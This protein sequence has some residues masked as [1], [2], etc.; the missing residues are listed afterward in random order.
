MKEKILMVAAGEMN[1]RGVKFTLDHVAVGAGISKKTIYR[2]FTSKNV[3]ITEIIEVALADVE[4]QEREILA[5]EERS[6]AE[7]LTD[8]MLL[9]PKKFGKTNDWVMED[10]KRYCNKDW[11]KIEQFK[12]ERMLVMN[13]FLEEGIALGI[14]QNINTKV[15]ARLL[16]GACRE[17]SQYEFLVENNLDSIQVRQLLT[18][19]FLHG[20]LT[21]G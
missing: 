15:A 10:I 6:F 18:E 1:K 21:K 3:L 7:K 16:L 9:E 17:L 4:N 12:Y 2:Y 20:I 19:I 8:L 14:V 5:N 11:E 13:Q